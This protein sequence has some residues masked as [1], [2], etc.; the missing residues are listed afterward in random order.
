MRWK[1]SHGGHDPRQVDLLAL[2]ALLVLIV[3][4]Y[5]YFTHNPKTPDNSAFIVPSQSTRW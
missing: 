4:G 1:S 2:I 3:A 5:L